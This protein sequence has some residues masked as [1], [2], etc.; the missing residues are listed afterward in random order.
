M[1]TSPKELNAPRP[2]SPAHLHLA[3]KPLLYAVPCSSAACTSNK[4]AT[5][6]VQS[7]LTHRP[8]S[9]SPARLS[10][11][12]KQINEIK[13]F[14]LTAR[15]KDAKCARNILPPNPPALPFSRPAVAASQR[16]RQIIASIF[17]TLSSLSLTRSRQDQEVEG[18]R[19][20]Q[21]PLQQVPLHPVRQG[22]GEG[23]Q[24]QA[25]AAARPDCQGHLKKEWRWCWIRTLCYN[26]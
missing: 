23:G 16:S 11:Q 8:L 20:V 25:V 5:S 10:A 2:H 13:D 14:L 18:C 6:C 21:G 24:A 15:R 12:P 3:A 4:I 1:V 7:R 22:F 19:Q 9:A 26:L 17:L